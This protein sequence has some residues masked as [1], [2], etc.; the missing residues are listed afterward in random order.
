MNFCGFS[1]IS[2]AKW[3]FSY[4]FSSEPHH[5]QDYN[6]IIAVV[7]HSPYQQTKTIPSQLGVVCISVWT[8]LNSIHHSLF[9]RLN[10][11]SNV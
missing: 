4:K 11:Q 8:A 1:Q 7:E 2:E 3:H 9:E 5:M 10:V 6:N